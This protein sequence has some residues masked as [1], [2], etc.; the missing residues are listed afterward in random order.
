MSEEAIVE[1]TTYEAGYTNDCNRGWM[2]DALLYFSK[3]GG[4]LG[5]NYP[6]IAGG[7]GKVSGTPKVRGICTD[8]HRIFLGPANVTVHPPLSTTEIKTLLVNKGPL[9]AGVYA[10]T[11]FDFYNS[12][13]FDACP[14][15][16][17][18]YANDAILLYGYDNQG[19][20]LI[21]NAWGPNWGIGGKMVLS[22][23]YD[24]G[25][26]ENLYSLEIPNI[27]ANVEVMMNITY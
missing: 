19:N 6:Y 15:Y 21:K 2:E 12:G 24:C 26:S 20:W 16:S 14:S 13:V 18:Y 27:N 5:A 7:Y 17:Y 11:A 23:I 3:V 8:P 22:S 4:V 10:N 1:C 25:L 9:I